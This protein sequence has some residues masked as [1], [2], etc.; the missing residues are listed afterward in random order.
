MAQSITE[1]LDQIIAR[2]QPGGE[3]GKAGEDILARKKVE[4]LARQRQSLASAGLAGTTIGAGLETAFEEITN[5][6]FGCEVYLHG[7]SKNRCK[8]WVGSHLS[9]SNEIYYAEG[10]HFDMSEDNSWNE[11]VSVDDDGFEMYLKLLGMGF[12][13]SASELPKKAEP[14]QVAEHLWRRFTHVLEY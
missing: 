4:T 3:F 1:L 11:Q 13:Y 7:Q 5:T 14:E 6:K 12:G 2:Y 8:I 10:Q 9:S